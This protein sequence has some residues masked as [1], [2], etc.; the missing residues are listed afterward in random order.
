M[1]PP[2]GQVR[3]PSGNGAPEDRDVHARVNTSYVSD[4]PTTSGSTPIAVNHTTSYP[5]VTPP[6]AVR[7]LGSSSPQSATVYYNMDDSDDNDSEQY[8]HAGPVIDG[9]TVC[10]HNRETMD[11]QLQ[12][13]SELM[14]Q[15]LELRPE[16]LHKITSNDD[17]GMGYPVTPRSESRG[18]RQCPPGS[19]EVNIKELGHN[20]TLTSKQQQ[21]IKD[22]LQQEHEEYRQAVAAVTT[23]YPQRYRVDLLEVGCTAGQIELQKAIEGKRGC[24]ERWSRHDYDLSDKRGYDKAASKLAQLL[25]RHLL[26]TPPS[27]VFVDNHTTTATQLPAHQRQLVSGKRIWRNSVRLALHQ[28]NLGGQVHLHH[29]ED[30][31]AWKLMASED[32][33]TAE[34]LRRTQRVHHNECI[35]NLKDDMQ[36]PVDKAHRFQTSDPEFILAVHRPPCSLHSYHSQRDQIANACFS[37]AF[38]ST[39]A[40]VVTRH[41]VG[42]CQWFED[43]AD[44]IFTSWREEDVNQ[45][46]PF[47]QLCELNLDQQLHPA[48]HDLMKEAAEVE[49]KDPADE[50]RNRQVNKLRTIHKNLGHPSNELMTKIL[51]E[52]GAPTD[53]LKL[54]RE[55]TCDVCARFRHTPPARPA[56]ATHPR[57]LG[58]HLGID[59]SLIH[60]G[61][62]KRA[63]LLLHFLDEASKFH[64]VRVI[65]EGIEDNEHVLG[66]ID[67]PTLI[68]KLQQCWLP[69]FQTPQLIHCDSEGVFKSNALLKLAQSRG[70]RIVN[71]AGEAHWQLGIVERHIQTITELIQKLADDNDERLTTQELCDLAAEAKNSFGHYGGYSP[72]QWQLSKQHPLTRSQEIPPG[73]EE[74]EF[75]CHVKRRARA[76][77]HFHEAEAKT[78]LRIASLAKARQLSTVNPGDIVYYFRRGKAAGHK[79]KGSYRGPAKVLAVEPPEGK[80]S[81]AITTVWLAHGSQLIR[82]AP[83]HLRQATPLEVRLGEF[84]QGPAAD[85]NRFISQTLGNGRGKRPHYYDLGARPSPAELRQDEQAEGD[86]DTVEERSAKRPR[87]NLMDPGHD[88]GPEPGT[89]G[90]LPEGSEDKLDTSSEATS[91]NRPDTPSARSDKYHASHRHPL[92]QPYE[93]SPR[94]R[95]RRGGFEGNSRELFQPSTPRRDHRPEIPPI[96][97]LPPTPPDGNPPSPPQLPPQLQPQPVTPELSVPPPATPMEVSEPRTPSG[98]VTAELLAEGELGQDKQLLREDQEGTQVN[99]EDFKDI[100]QLAEDAIKHIVTQQVL[101]QSAE[102]NANVAYW[103]KLRKFAKDSKHEAPC[104]G[105]NHHSKD[106]RKIRKGMWPDNVVEYSMDIFDED[107][108]IFKDSELPDKQLVDHFALMTTEAKRHAEVII[109]N[110]TVNEKNE[111]EAA[112]YKELDQWISHSVFSIVKRAGIPLDRVMT[113]RWVLTWK[114]PDNAK[115]GDRKAKA[116][117]V[118]KG[119]SDPDLTTIRAE[120]PTLSRVG[121]HTLLQLTASNDWQLTKG[122]VKTAFLQGDSE[123]GKRQVYV[124]PTGEVRK[125]LGMTSDQLMKLERA[126]YGLRNAPRAWY[127]RIRRDLIAMG[128]RP[129]QLDSCLFMIYDKGKLVGMVGVYVDD[130]LIVGDNKS[131][132]WTT[133]KQKLL[134]AYTW[135]PWEDN[136]FTFTGVRLQKLKTG[137]IKLTQAEYC[138]KQLHQV[139]IGK[140]DPETACT[141]DQLTQLRGADGSLQ[142]LATNTRLDLGAPVSIAQGNHSKP[143]VKHLQDS[144]KLIRTAYATSDTPLYIQ[145]IPMGKL[146][147]AQFHDAGQGSRPDGSSQG[148]YVT[149]AADKSLLTGTEQLCS[150]LDWKSFK[151]KRV[152][153]SSLSAEVQAFAE[154]LDALEFLKL[155]LAEALSDKPLDLRRDADNAIATVCPSVLVTDCKSLYDAVE[156]SQSTGLNLAERRTSIEVL[157]CRERLH[158]TK[159]E[160]KWVNSD[161]QLADGLTKASAAWKLTRFQHKPLWKLVYD[162]TFTAAKKMKAP[163]KSMPSDNDHDIATP[164]S[165]QKP[166]N[167][168]STNKYKLMQAGKT[169]RRTPT[170]TRRSSTLV[171][172]SA[173]QPSAPV[174]NTVAQACVQELTT[175]GAKRKHNRGKKNVHFS[176]SVV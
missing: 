114:I 127:T 34:L 16:G 136:D 174:A 95:S 12:K 158:A 57:E 97:Q 100:K 9:A 58:E 1:A 71:T 79:Q 83:E 94:S 3:G 159:M 89:P 112:K 36:V 80:E 105:V 24:Y 86:E 124:D 38:A 123:E 32:P 172:A 39:I 70:I 126:V 125:K 69:Y 137:A 15:L 78:I 162:P 138:T 49:D 17:R 122:D 96:Y 139:S 18:T 50:L 53:V 156:R 150:V 90:P 111:F 63:A 35:D 113:M 116:R 41:A 149:V 165:S 108:E 154:A 52:A 25:P 68:E 75:F 20:A 47:C 65:K 157:S 144:N 120:A 173:I 46:A 160:L 42:L 166:A 59:L 140:V 31:R 102:D 29:P 23:S 19:E 81:K 110:L 109:R 145:P 55:L 30:S 62:D 101:A 4:T 67:G 148:G 175:G 2:Y 130:C 91:F 13:I 64:I 151:L 40:T 131:R 22:S 170:T 72:S 56:T 37:P 73:D 84:V 43:T 155:V 176:Q 171:N 33:K 106:P 134:N 93:D 128:A 8:D 82:A 142:W 129:H 14:K 7:R 152:A 6:P 169:T 115:D 133:F 48:H 103:T 28:L 153:R 61:P 99:V 92:R 132:A 118:V 147:M 10:A 74:D 54:V 104:F 88:A 66:N 164:Q 44:K 5:P 119:F 45:F 168:H 167:A 51:R 135:S 76:A 121:K 146:A 87:V 27:S 163:A 107:L 60:I 161:R 11:Q 143:Q 98:I 141:P 26:L 21:L 85:P 77:K 117:L